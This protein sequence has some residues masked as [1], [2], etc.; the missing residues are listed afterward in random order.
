MKGISGVGSLDNK[1]IN[2]LKR[3]ALLREFAKR[4]DDHHR[5]TINDRQ[6]YLTMLTKPINK[7]YCDSNLHLTIIRSPGSWTTYEHL[8]DAVEGFK[9]L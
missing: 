2:D 8:E 6:T 5:I 3:V 7:V 9:L 4:L 1:D